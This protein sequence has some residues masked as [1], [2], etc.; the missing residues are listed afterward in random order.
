VSERAA[1]GAEFPNL[2]VKSRISICSWIPIRDQVKN[3]AHVGW[4]D[5]CVEW[6]LGVG[7][8]KLHRNAIRAHL[9]PKIRVIFVETIDVNT[10]RLGTAGTTVVAASYTDIIE[11]A[12]RENCDSRGENRGW[13]NCMLLPHDLASSEANLFGISR[14]VKHSSVPNLP[15]HHGN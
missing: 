3:H 4:T 12:S 2:C 10:V 1:R 8:E 9:P 5:A 13:R 14:N 11:A 7:A 15:G 6:A